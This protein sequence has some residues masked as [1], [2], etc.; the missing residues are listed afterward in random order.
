MPIGVAL[1]SH[2]ESG[3][4]PK[5]GR[6]L[7]ERWWGICFCFFGVG[8]SRRRRVFGHRMWARWSLAQG[9]L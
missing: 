5:P 7:R 8:A 4:H 9:D 1:L 2:T 3:C 6:R